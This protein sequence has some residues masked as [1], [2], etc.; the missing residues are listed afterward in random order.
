MRQVKL[1]RTR[2]TN[3]STLGIVFLPSGQII[4]SLENP[5]LGNRRNVSCIPEG[6]YL[7]KWLPRSGSGKYKRVWHVQDVPERSG[8]LWHAGNYPRHTLG[9]ILPG[10]KRGKNVVYSSVKALNLMRA[11]LAE[12]DFILQ[13]STL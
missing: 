13:I 2:H 4:Y 10:I 1:I 3:L 6:E 11:E 8:I 5:W 9:C 12:S 7:C